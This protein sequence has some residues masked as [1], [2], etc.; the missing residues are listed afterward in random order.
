VSIQ[1][2]VELRRPRISEF[3]VQGDRVAHEAAGVESEYGRTVVAGKTLAGRQQGA[4]DASTA[5]S[6][7]DGERPAAGPAAWPAEV[8]D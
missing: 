8:L 5:G 6:G 4:C 1:V 3:L 7:V 2:D